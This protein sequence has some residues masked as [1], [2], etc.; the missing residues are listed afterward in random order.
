MISLRSKPHGLINDMESSTQPSAL[1]L[2]ASLIESSIYSPN[3]DAVRASL[4][5]SGRRLDIASTKLAGSSPFK[6]SA[7]EAVQNFCNSGSPCSAALY[8][9]MSVLRS[10]GKNSMPDDELFGGKLTVFTLTSQKVQVF[11]VVRANTSDAQCCDTAGQPSGT[12]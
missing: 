3:Q 12:S 9:L 1:T 8:S 10:D 7:L 5:T 11:S 6:I 2:R 4:S